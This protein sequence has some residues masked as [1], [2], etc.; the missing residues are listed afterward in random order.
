MKTICIEN[1]ISS[2]IWWWV[3]FWNE[4]QVFTTYEWL[5]VSKLRER[6]IERFEKEI[7]KLSKQQIFDILD[8]Q[9]NIQIV[10]NLWNNRI[11][12]LYQNIENHP[13]LTKTWCCEILW[14]YQSIKKYLPKFHIVDWKNI[15]NYNIIQILK[16]E[17]LKKF[18]IWEK[19]I[20]KHP[21]LDWN[22]NWVYLI[23][24]D[25]NI[26][27][28]IEKA[29]NKFNIKLKDI[30]RLFG[31]DYIIQEYI[32]N[33]VLEWS[34][35]FNIQNWWFDNWGLVNNCVIDWEYF[36]S[37]NYFT[38]I[39]INIVKELENNIFR[40]FHEL[41]N[42]LK[43]QWIRWNIWFDIII[44]SWNNEF[45]VH[46]LECNWLYRTT[47]STLPN[48]FAYNTKNPLFFWIPLHIRYLIEEYQDISELK[49]LKIEEILRKQWTKQWQEQIINF[50]CDWLEYNYP[51]IWVWTSW[52]DFNNLV[53]LIQETWI[54][55]NLWRNYINNIISNIT[56]F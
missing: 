2:A 28:N 25:E 32:K 51:V 21:L 36:A 19:I 54:I 7:I 35:T 1:N 18:S 43:K 10:S 46:I 34:I 44:S 11:P 5:A 50:K 52:N 26:E 4:S 24:V 6:N 49:L 17:I 30:N 53:Q 9:S 15:N 55:N 16:S 12:W 22:W 45:K 29:L 40:D 8:E 47:W 27:Q 23:N 38:K 20:I 13:I 3:R 37:T 56:N 31:V 39:N 41:L 33:K 42:N 14:N 48:N